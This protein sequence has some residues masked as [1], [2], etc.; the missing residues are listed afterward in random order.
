MWNWLHG[1]L[2]EGCSRTMRHMISG[3]FDHGLG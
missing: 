2:P 1:S 3:I